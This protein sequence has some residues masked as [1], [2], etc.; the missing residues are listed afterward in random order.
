MTTLRPVFL[1]TETTGLRAHQ[2]RIIEVACYDPVKD[3]TFVR[4]IN[5]GC[6]IPAEAS[7]IHKINDSMVADA[8]PFEQVGP[9]LL[10]FLDPNVI[11][12]AH[13]GDAFDIPFLQAEFRRARIPI[14]RWRTLD[15]LKWSRRYRRD[16]PRHSLQFLVQTYG[17]QVTT[18]HRALADVIALHQV[19]SHMV[20]DLSWD[21][22]Y[23]LS[24]GL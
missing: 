2:D 9:E 23:T 13:N 8:P 24:Q 6:P 12:V 15:T 16:L 22:I 3:R 4:L 20:D 14:T 18:A 5:P 19:F 11:L 7:S 10:D 17:V 21:T 1:D